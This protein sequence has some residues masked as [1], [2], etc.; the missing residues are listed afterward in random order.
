MFIH[1]ADAFCP[2]ANKEEQDNYKQ[3]RVDSNT[4]DIKW[5]KLIGCNEIL[6]GQILDRMI[7]SL[8]NTKDTLLMC[9]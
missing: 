1:L 2:R 6:S 3:N 5:E 4:I 7:L 8:H 9:C